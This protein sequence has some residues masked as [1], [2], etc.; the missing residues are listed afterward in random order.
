VFGLLH[1]G[2]SAEHLGDKHKPHYW[3]DFWALAGLWEAAQLATRLGASETRELWD[4]YDEVRTATAASIRWVLNEQLRLGHWEAF[5]PTGPADV[6]RLD[7]TIIGATAYFHPC[8]LHMGEKLGPDIH[9]AACMTLETIWAH[10]VDSS[11][12]FFHDKAWHAYGPYLTL[13]LAHAFLFTGDIKRMDQCLAWSVGNAGYAKLR[14]FAGAASPW[15]VVQG[16]WNEQHCIPVATDFSSPN[17]PGWWYMGDI[18]HG[19]AAAEFILLLRDILFF[20]ADE[21]HD[22]H[23]YI[24][25]G[26]PPHW[27]EDASQQDIVLKDA[28]TCFGSVF[29][30]ELHH[31]KAAKTITI[32]IRQPVSTSV[33][34]VYPCHL[35]SSVTH[36]DVDGQSL[37][38]TGRNIQLPSGFSRA[39]IQYS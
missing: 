28:P 6:G 7:S 33:R 38:V 13:Q 21:D 24:A 8:R 27:L 36:I 15:E 29:G 32:N 37:P 9:H 19:W 30:Y 2:W 10:C 39:Q 4:I 26:V 11:G 12:G 34:Y 23:I 22:P 3:D 17:T 35:G 20:E 5:I 18:P 31:D 14:G 16:V 1:S 25:P